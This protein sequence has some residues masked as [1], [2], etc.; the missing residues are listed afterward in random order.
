MIEENAL[1]PASRDPSDA[2]INP[3]NYGTSDHGRETFQSE[4]DTAG[5][6]N[7]AADVDG[8]E[9]PRRPS[10]TK[11]ALFAGQEAPGAGQGIDDMD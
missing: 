1:L 5:F 8:G 11:Q 4:S 3:S 9:A 2:K 6:Q 10:V 7:S